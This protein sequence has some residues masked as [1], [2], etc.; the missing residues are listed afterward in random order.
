MNKK[1]YQ[2]RK[3]ENRWSSESNAKPRLSIA[4]S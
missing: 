3:G 4:E 2:K 1:D